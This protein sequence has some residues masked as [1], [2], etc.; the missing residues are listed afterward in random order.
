[1]G[2]TPVGRLDGSAIPVYRFPILAT[3]ADGVFVGD[4]MKA[5]AGGNV[6]AADDG[7]DTVMI[8]ACVGI[9]DTDGVTIGTHGSSVSTK[10]LP[11]TT[12]GYA[13]V[14]LAL[15]DSVFK[16]QTAGSLAA[17]DIFS[18]AA[19]TATA[20]NTTIA[21]SAHEITGTAGTTEPFKIIGKVEEPG[22]AWGTNVELKVVPGKSY[23]FT[24]VTG[25]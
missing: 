1:M 3:Q 17:V 19:L 8:G 22:N 7:D 13:Y 5:L 10:Y 2:F 11:A 16:A 15:P 20:G 23:W 18:A 6:E 21:R 12:G 24:P 25:I 14:A 4:W 9:E